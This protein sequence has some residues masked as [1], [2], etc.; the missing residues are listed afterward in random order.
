MD[1][2]NS[3][4]VL[5]FSGF[6]VYEFPT[7]TKLWGHYAQV[8]ADSRRAGHGGREGTEYYR[9]HREAMD[10]GAAHKPMAEYR[11]KKGEVFGH[12]RHIPNVRK[13]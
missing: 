8:R 12:H 3:P 1:F 5:G 4:T 9:K 11:R 7:N 6:S 10:A 2:F 13:Q